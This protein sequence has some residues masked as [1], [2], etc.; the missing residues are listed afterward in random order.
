MTTEELRCKAAHCLRLAD[1][2]VPND[3]AEWL[4]R[5]ADEYEN[6]ARRLEAD[7]VHNAAP[8]PA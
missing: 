7:G 2:A 4:R 6:E 5:L 3:V 1:G 8:I